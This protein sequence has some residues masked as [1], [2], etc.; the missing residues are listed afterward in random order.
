M[1]DKIKKEK[2]GLKHRN[3]NDLPVFDADH[4]FLIAFEKN[5][6]TK[7]ESLENTYIESFKKNQ[8]KKQGIKVT[9]PRQTDHDLTQ[10]HENFSELLEESFKKRKVKSVKKTSPMSVKKRLKRY[11]SVEAEL[12]LHGYNTIGAQM[13]ARSFI[14]SC[15]HKG[16]FT[17]RI[18]V[19]KGLHSDAGPVLPDVVEDVVREMKKLDQ[20]I[21]YEWD[22]KKKTRSG[23]LIVYLKQFE[24][25]D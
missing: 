18:I 20:V 5:V 19:G 6:Q 4:D 7:P 12:D 1:A 13:R 2:K 14:S 23:A 25:F 16:F 22:K 10:S 15:K 8:T 21:F 24:Q 11:P 9:D 3:K 17:L